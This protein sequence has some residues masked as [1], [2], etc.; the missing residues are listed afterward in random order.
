MSQTLTFR[1]GVSSFLAAI[2]ACSVP[3]ESKITFSNPCVGFMHAM[4]FFVA[5]VNLELDVET[6]EAYYSMPR[7]LHQLS[8]KGFLNCSN[9]GLHCMLLQQQRRGGLLNAFMLC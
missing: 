7:K 4:I 3:Y 1:V 5:N 2:R 6:K 9:F 8:L